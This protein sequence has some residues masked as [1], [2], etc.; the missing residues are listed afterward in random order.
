MK[1][2]IL[3]EKTE[4]Q[5][6]SFDSIEVLCGVFKRMSLYD[7]GHPEINDFYTHIKFMNEL[8]AIPTILDRI[9][10][11]YFTNKNLDTLSKNEICINCMNSPKLIKYVPGDKNYI[12]YLAKY[13]MHKNDLLS[14][15]LNMSGL[16]SEKGKTKLEEIETSLD[17]KNKIASTSNKDLVYHQKLEP[18]YCEITSDS[19]G[20]IT[21]KVNSHAPDIH[22]A[23]ENAVESYNKIAKVINRPI[24]DLNAV[25]GSESSEILT[26]K[27]EEQLALEEWEKFSNERTPRGRLRNQKYFG[28][29]LRMFRK[30]R[31]IK[32]YKMATDLGITKEDLFEME[33]SK[34]IP[35]DKN[36]IT[37]I[38]EYLN[39][40]ETKMASLEK[41]YIESSKIIPKIQ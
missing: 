37:N 20:R 7:K 13:E 36:L 25:V 17:E 35:K 31:G 4:H 27:N 9:F 22:T 26:N 38:G 14:R 23:I 19:E 18:N 24:I 29:K 34:K 12:N 21:F 33:M 11:K 10:K 2:I 8:T 30:N 39:L 15:I 40:G 28:N 1:H 16:L 5:H 41:S 6:D 3:Y 32:I